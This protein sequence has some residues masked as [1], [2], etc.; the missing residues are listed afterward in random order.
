MCK[1]RTTY[2]RKISL[3]NI[4]I[5][6]SQ[7]YS[8]ISYLK[9]VFPILLEKSY[10]FFPTI[11]KQGC[12]VWSYRDVRRLYR[13]SRKTLATFVFLISRLPRGLGLPYWTFFNSSFCLD[14][15]NI[16]FFIIWWNM[17][18]DIAKISSH[19]YGAMPPWGLIST[20]EHS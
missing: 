11:E 18:W 20:H 19:E 7:T 1:Y 2:N 12:C 17:E 16:H 10:S 14:F 6:T 15:R 3:L 8:Y 5:C 13:V 4:V 9:F